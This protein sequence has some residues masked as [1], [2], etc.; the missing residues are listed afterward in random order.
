LNEAAV[1]APPDR[2]RGAAWKIERT[3]QY[4][5]EGLVPGTYKVTAKCLQND[6]ARTIVLQKSEIVS[7][8]D[9]ELAQADF[10]LR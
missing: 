7:V 3:G 5:I 6:K 4:S 10:D 1:L 2:W 9:G 8:K